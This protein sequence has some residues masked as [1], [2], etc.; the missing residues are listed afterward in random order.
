MSEETEPALASAPAHQRVMQPVTADNDWLTPTSIGRRTPDRVRLNL[1]RAWIIALTV[2]I[3]YLWIA[4]V[5]GSSRLS[6]P[7]LIDLSGSHGVHVED[8]V[9]SACWLIAMVGLRRAWVRGY[10]R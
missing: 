5:A 1:S 6:G 4:A 10:G 9:T 8:L 7:V 3:T 2:G